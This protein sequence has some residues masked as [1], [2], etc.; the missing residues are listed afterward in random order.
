MEYNNSRD[1]HDEHKEEKYDYDNMN[2]FMSYP[3]MSMP[4][5]PMYNYPMYNYPMYSHPMCGYPMNCPMLMKQPYAPMMPG[6]LRDEYD[7]Y[8]DYDDY[9]EED[10]YPDT[11][12]EGGRRRRRRRRRRR[13]PFRP[14]P[15]YPMPFFF[16]RPRPFRYDDGSDDYI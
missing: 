1:H 4:F 16:S 7:D 9:D 14:M 8:D 3:Q 15:F 2:Q 10:D 11:F 6:N 5:N 13:F 12:R